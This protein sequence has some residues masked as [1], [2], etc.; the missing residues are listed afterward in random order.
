MILADLKQ[1]L[2]QHRQVALCDLTARFD[3][4][5][6]AVRAML[7]VLERKGRVRRL[8]LGTL[9]SSGC[10]Q[11]SPDSVEIYEYLEPRSPG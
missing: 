8:P 6:T 9:C 3:A 11:C 7:E 10:K 2:A 4:D 1:Y 5:E